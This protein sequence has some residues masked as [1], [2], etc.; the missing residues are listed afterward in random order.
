MHWT[1]WI[2]LCLFV[3]L[4][5]VLLGS[6]SGGGGGGAHLTSARQQQQASTTS[7]AETQLVLPQLNRELTAKLARLAE[8][9]RK[10][11]SKYEATT[12]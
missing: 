4:P 9:I 1:R 2:A 12:Q 8:Q 3:M 11:R 5:L 10:V 6:S 7:S